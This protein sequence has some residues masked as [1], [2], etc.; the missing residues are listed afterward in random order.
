[1][2]NLMFLRNYT[3]DFFQENLNQKLGT[4]KEVSN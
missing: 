2:F 4:Y 1:M 3:L